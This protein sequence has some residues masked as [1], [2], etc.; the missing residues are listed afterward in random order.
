MVASRLKPL[1]VK[2]IQKLTASPP[3]TIKHRSLGG[4]PGFVLVHTPAGCTGYGLI[5]R[6]G[7]GRLDHLAPPFM[8]TMV[9][10][11]GW[12]RSTT[13]CGDSSSTVSTSST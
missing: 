9:A 1:T 5:Y 10:A 13:L 6:A 3:P 4:V 7:G 8:R 12:M 11:I 2:E